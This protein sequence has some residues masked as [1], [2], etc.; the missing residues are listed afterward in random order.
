MTQENLFDAAPSQPT[1][2]EHAR[3]MIAKAFEILED[4]ETLLDDQGPEALPYVES[5]NRELADAR[6]EVAMLEKA[7]I[8]RRKP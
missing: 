7:E 2:L 4:A 1:P 6:A 3:R 5:A 8:E